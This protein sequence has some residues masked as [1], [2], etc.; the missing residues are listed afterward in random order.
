MSIKDFPT[1]LLLLIL[2]YIAPDITLDTNLFPYADSN[3]LF[4][5]N[6]SCLSKKR[7]ISWSE[8]SG[9]PLVNDNLSQALDSI[10]HLRVFSEISRQFRYVSFLH[11]FWKK[12]CWHLSLAKK[13]KKISPPQKLESFFDVYNIPQRTQRATA[14]WI[15]LSLLDIEIVITE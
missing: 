12:L 13:K 15:D 10:S 4:P 9:K 7:E 11:P 6:S 3:S 14:I 2:L 8:I 5:L 1:E